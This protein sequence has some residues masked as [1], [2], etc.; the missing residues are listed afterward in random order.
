[1]DIG[2]INLSTL[3]ERG[4]TDS[5][6]KEMKLY[7]DK[8]TPNP[9]IINSAPMK[10]YNKKRIEELENTEEFKNLRAKSRSKNK[11]AIKAERSV[12][13]KLYSYV[14]TVEIETKYAS[15]PE[16]TD[17]AIF[18]YNLLHSN[19]SERASINSDKLFLNQIREEYIIHNLT[20][21][22][23]II[24]EIDGHSGISEEVYKYLEKRIR[25]RCKKEWKARSKLIDKPQ[26]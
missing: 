14:E 21:Y 3:K 19:D 26:H 4:W 17:S 5:I 20:N 11:G 6:I 16:L 24:A 12:R 13:G 8:T 22:D 9:H 15:E 2:Y 18:S 25:G 1:M 7:P 23:A 10:L